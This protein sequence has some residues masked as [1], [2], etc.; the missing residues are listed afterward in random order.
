VADISAD[1]RKSVKST[2]F[3][4]LFISIDPQAFLTGKSLQQCLEGNP[5]PATQI[6]QTVTILFDQRKD[7]LVPE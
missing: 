4:I 5:F 3:Y 7:L 1:H 2:F 6:D